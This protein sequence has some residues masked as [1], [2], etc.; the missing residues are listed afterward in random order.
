MGREGV[1]RGLGRRRAPRRRE[2]G[3]RVREGGARSRRLPRAARRAGRARSRST[4]TRTG[5][6]SRFLSALDLRP[7]AAADHER[8]RV[9]HAAPPARAARRGGARGR[10]PARP[11]GRDA[12]RAAGGGARRPHRAPCSSRPCCS[13]TRGIVPGLDELARACEAAGA[14]LL[15]DAYHAL[16]CLPFEL[17][18][19]RRPGSSAA[20]TSTSSSARATASS[21]SRRTPTSCG[22]RSPAGS[23]SSRSWRRR[24]RRAPSSTRA[25]APA[26]PARPTTRRATT[27][28][29]ASSTSSSEQGLTPERLR[30]RYLHQ[31]TLLARRPRRP[32]PR[33]RDPTASRS[34]ASS[35]SSSTTPRRS[36]AAWRKR[37]WLTDSR[38]RFLRLRAGAVPL[39]RP[40]RGGPRSPRRMPQRDH[41]VSPV[42]VDAPAGEDVREHSAGDPQ[43]SV[44]RCRP[45][46]ARRRGGSPPIETGCVPS[47]LRAAITHRSPPAPRRLIACTVGIAR[48]Q[49]DR[50]RRVH[51]RRRE[52]AERPDLAHERLEHVLPVRPAPAVRARRPRSSTAGGCRRRR[53]GCGR[54]SGSP[55]TTM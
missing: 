53:R 27:A 52:R 28:R 35:R 32:R 24:R 36:A 39:R 48:G 51:E 47:P 6:C 17:P 41:R 18:L 5:S 40:A 16:G 3:A 55:C 2:V 21:A 37:A 8:R 7:A 4:R 26:S 1:R 12:R 42:H 50:R 20:A 15:V 19:G 33:G 23:P 45:R 10:P 29:R 34:A 54:R 22:P 46:R 9:P 14:E 13:R 11:P 38:A 44:P 43:P 30:E 31:T 49:H 25:A